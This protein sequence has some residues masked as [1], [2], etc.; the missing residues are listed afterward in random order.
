[1]FERFSASARRSLVL[2]QKE[3]RGLN[4]NCVGSQHLLLTLTGDKELANQASTPSESPTLHC[5]ATS[6]KG[7]ARNTDGASSGGCRRR[8][9]ALRLSAGAT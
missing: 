8:M 3:T 2:A 1:V 5:A 6:W 7:S 9:G 4:H